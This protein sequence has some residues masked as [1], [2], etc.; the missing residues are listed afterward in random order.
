MSGLLWR[1]RLRNQYSLGLHLVPPARYSA[2]NE[3]GGLPV[4]LPNRACS[5][6]PQRGRQVFPFSVSEFR[7]PALV[8]CAQKLDTKKPLFSEQPPIR[9]A[10]LTTGAQTL[11]ESRSSGLMDQ[12][13]ALFETLP[14]FLIFLGQDG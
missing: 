3:I 10:G 6:P 9:R 14:C 12:K 11:L 4:I 13:G 5:L 1:E 7:I 2:Q 8:Y